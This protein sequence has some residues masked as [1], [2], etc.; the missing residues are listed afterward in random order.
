MTGGEKVRFCSHCSFEVNNLSALTRKEAMKLVRRT[1]GRI[2]VRYIKNPVDDKPL[3]AEKLYQITRRAGIAAGVLSA[4]LSLSTLAY[5]QGEPVLT[6]SDSR[7]EISE[8]Q[9]DTEKDKNEAPTATI[10]GVVTDSTGAAISKTP[11]VLTNQT[12]KQ[13]MIFETNEEGLY[14]IKNRDAGSY[15]LNFP[16]GVG[17]APKNIEAFTV[18]NGAS[19]EKDVTLEINLVEVTMGML[20]VTSPREGIHLAVASDNSE[21]VRELIMRGA[22]VNQKDKNYSNITPLFVAVENGNAETA[23]MLLNFG[24][25]VNARDENR[26]TPLMRLDEDA[27]VEIVRLLFNHGARVNVVDNERNT[28]LILAARSVKADVVRLLINHSANL[29]AQNAEGRTALMEAADADNTEVV[30]ALLE[31][32]ALVNLKDNDGETAHDLTT[33]NEIEKLLIEYGANVPQDSN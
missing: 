13:T 8:N 2:C 17:F 5:A 14:E 28:A 18:A 25:K 9:K 29:N 32:G 30:R 24:A 16:G 11:V 22:N 4:S 10:F 27:S 15:S 26:Q 12:T 7:I 19:V 23:E 31:A 21:E 33:E 20:L 3:F 1:E 6:K